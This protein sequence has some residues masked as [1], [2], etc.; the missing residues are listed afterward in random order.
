[1]YFRHTVFGLA[2]FAFTYPAWSF[3]WGSCTYTT[4]EYTLT[5]PS[6]TEL[7]L[8]P[9]AANGTVLYS[10]RYSVGVTGS[11]VCP[12]S[13]SYTQKL[14]YILTNGTTAGSM[15]G[16]ELIS[17]DSTYP[18]FKT[19]V[20]GIGVVFRSDSKALPYFLFTDLINNTVANAWMMSFSMDLIKYGTITPGLRLVE[21]K[22]ADMPTLEY[23]YNVSGS[24]NTTGPTAIPNGSATVSRIKIASATFSVLNATC[25]TPDVSVDLGIRGLSD[26][27]NQSG[28][29]FVTPWVDSSIR[30]T[31]C[32]QFHGIGGRKYEGTTHDNVMTVTLI[33]N[34]ATTSG[35]GIMPVDAGS[36]A[37]TG[38][39][40]QLANG[41]AASPQLVSFSAGK[42]EQKFT[43]SSS[44]GQNYTIPLVARYIQTAGSVN[45]IM[46][47]KAN[48]KITYL[49]NYY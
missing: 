41:T 3:S 39:G 10:V 27:A 49:I 13:N 2:L 15:S 45:D 34:N 36:D 25:N 12:N 29:K 21:I 31:G 37:A 8:D 24:L 23:V 16:Y 32:P 40:I 46:P 4:N 43:M 30:L 35:K 22:S 14:G 20:D 18:V 48:G 42:A 26:S 7:S 38:V 47:G 1:M 11:M 44:Q 6:G 5:P 33:P 19:S 28:G 9:N 17:M